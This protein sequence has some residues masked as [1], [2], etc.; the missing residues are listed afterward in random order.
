MRLRSKWIVIAGAIAAIPAVTLGEL[1]LDIRTPRSALDE[2][3]A[4]TTSM[5]ILMADLDH[6][7]KVMKEKYGP[8]AETAVETHPP[9]VITRVNGKVIRE[10][11]AP[12]Q[13]SDARGLFV[14]GQRGHLE[15]T[16]PFQ[17]DPREAPAFG[18]QGEPSVRYLKDSFGE[19]LSARYFEFDD[20]DAMTDT[21]VAISPTD[22]GL[23]GRQLRFQSA[24]FC[25]VF[26]KGPSRA[27]MLVGVA[28]ADGDPWMRPFSRR[29]CRWLTEVAL[30]RVAATDREA[31]PD[32][33]ACLLVDRPNRSGAAEILREHVFEVRRDA[34]LTYLK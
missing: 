5:S 17:I 14:V 18:R 11:R 2:V 24:T 15:S 4:I 34:S 26:W 29:I 7:A 30:E 6:A 1:M 20:R 21:C 27:S 23:V 13:F 9:R 28:L 25:V 32:Y 3:H 8:D 33:A 19:K 22:L 12:G 10:E 16:F 31:P